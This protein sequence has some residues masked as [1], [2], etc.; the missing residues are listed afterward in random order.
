MRKCLIVCWYGIL[1]NY[2]EIWEKSC[3]YNE[4]YDFLVV[5]DQEFKPF[6]KNIILKKISLSEL[7]KLINKKL[8]INV[9]LEKPYKLCD[10]R[11]AY[12]K[13]FEDFLGNY[14]F[15]GHCDIDQIFGK[16]SDFITDNILNNSEKINK[17]GHFCLY[18]NC[19]KVNELYKKSGSIFSYKEVFSNKENYAFDEKTG[20]NLIAEKN[21]IKTKYI[22]KYADIDIRF[23][24]YKTNKGRNYVNQAF[25]WDKGKIFRVYNNNL[26]KEEFMYLHFQ[27]KRPNIKVQ[28]K[29]YSKLIIGSNYFKEVENSLTV[30]D[31]IEC[32]PYK[33][34]LY[35]SIEKIKYII[36]K[37]LQF[38][39]CSSSQKRIWIR[40]KIGK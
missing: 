17:N 37:L 10:F 8:N 5:T 39:K 33:G 4:D 40:Q 2:F 25:I 20:I 32:N 11:P 36:N 27:K 23:K 22:E 30:N 35:E 31:I 12:G 6:S 15:W 29:K 19:E 24:R 3:S 16:I 28:N 21:E 34:S 26:D 14:E 9:K 18:K 7:N 1:P 38:I 13:I